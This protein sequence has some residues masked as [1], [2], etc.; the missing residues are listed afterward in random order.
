[1]KRNTHAKF[2][3]K[4]AKSF[5]DISEQSYVS[6]ADLAG[7]IWKPYC[8]WSGGFLLWNSLRL[9]LMTA[10]WNKTLPSA[11]W[12]PLSSWTSWPPN[13]QL[14]SST[15]R[16]GKAGL[17]QFD[18]INEIYLHNSFQRSPPGLIHL[19]RGFSLMDE[20]PEEGR[21]FFCRVFGILLVS[22][23]WDLKYFFGNSSACLLYAHMFPALIFQV[24]CF[25][26][27]HFDDYLL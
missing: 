22:S 8:V 17:H 2:Q 3:V 7:K 19:I 26:Q 5:R 13:V 15:L 12:N 1:M 20:T 11:T 4:W 21:R 24:T 14:V 18:L 6:M 27:F 10:C 9:L 16:S 25:V 23:L